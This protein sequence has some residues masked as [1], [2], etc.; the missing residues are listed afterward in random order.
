TQ[1][2]HADNQQQTQ[3]LPLLGADNT[4]W[5]TALHVVDLY[6]TNRIPCKECESQRVLGL[7]HTETEHVYTHTV[8]VCVRITQD[9]PHM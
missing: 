4:G 6:G 1:T 8:K 7:P 2:L 9:N 5:P 3:C